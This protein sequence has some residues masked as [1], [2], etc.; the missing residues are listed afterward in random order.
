[1]GDRFSAFADE[2]TATIALDD[3]LSPEDQR[4]LLGDLTEAYS[5]TINRVKR[6]VS[7]KQDV[8]SFAQLVDRQFKDPPHVRMLAEHLRE[9]EKYVE[10]KGEKGIGRLIV[11]MPPRHG[12]T[13][14]VSKRWPAYLLGRHRDWG[15]AEVSYGASLAEDA[16]RAVRAVIRDIPEYRLIFPETSLSDESSAVNRWALAGRHPDNPNFVA[17]GVGGPVT[18]RGFEVIIVDDPIK[19]R[20]EAESPT[21]RANLH[22]WFDGTL[23]TRLEPGGAIVIIQTR[24]HEDD[25]VGYLLDKDDGDDWTVLNLPAIAE[26]ALPDGRPAIDP[27]GREPGEALWPARWPLKTLLQIKR[28]LGP[29]DWESQFQGHPKP[30]GG[31]KIQREWFQTIQPQDVPKGLNWTRY[32]DLAISSKEGSSYT[33]SARLAY[34]QDGNLYVGGMIRGRWEWPQQKRI[35]KQ[36]MLTERVLGVEHG[37]EKALHGTAAVQDFRTDK[38]LIGVA[39]RGVDVEGDKLT[40]AL[41]WIAQA[42]D[43]SVHLIEGPWVSLFLDEAAAF[44]GHNDLYDDQIDTLS[45][46]VAMQGG[47]G[48]AVETSENPFYD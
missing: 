31:S 46:G 36:T 4:E 3:S 6:L 8:L 7:A 26:E 25:L 24:W 34:D 15:I 18:G 32:W 10:T 27:L 22:S 40:R 39:F 9:V 17:A 19:G 20:R 43:G 30:P 23:Y 41:P 28:V 14:T 5:Q 13:L 29:Y 47:G 1:M 16:S 21:V 33:A 42:A 38:D 44:T 12:K 48:D 35:I 11:S 37:I 2:Y 45:G